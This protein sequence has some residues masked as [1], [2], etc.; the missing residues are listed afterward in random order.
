MKNTCENCR[1]WRIK[2]DTRGI[3]DNPDWKVRN[4]VNEDLALQ[5][6]DELPNTRLQKI[7]IIRELLGIRTDADFGCNQHEINNNNG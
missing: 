1:F 2:S 3:C 5:F 4:S 7:N 6:V